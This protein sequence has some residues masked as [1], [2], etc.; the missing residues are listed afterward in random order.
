MTSQKNSFFAKVKQLILNRMLLEQFD[1]TST[2]ITRLFE[3]GHALEEE[4]NE[5][6]W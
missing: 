2:K 6:N 1:R 3:F 5:E 4:V